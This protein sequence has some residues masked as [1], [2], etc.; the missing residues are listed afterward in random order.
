MKPGG[1]VQP[2]RGHPRGK[3]EHAGERDRVGQIGGAQVTRRGGGAAGSGLLGDGDELRA[4]DQQGHQP[5]QRGRPQLRHRR[6]PDQ[7]RHQRRARQDDHQHGHL[8]IS[9][10]R[11]ADH[12][13]QDHRPPPPRPPRQPHRGLQRQRQEQR[14]R[15]QVQVIP[16][17]PRQ[18]R[19]QPEKRPRRDRAHLRGQPQPR[20]PVHRITQ[21]PR[22]HHRQ[23]VVRRARPEHHRDRH[24]HHARQRHQRM[25][26]QLS[27]RRSIDITGKPRITQ[28]L[29]LP[30]NPPEPPHVTTRITRRRQ[31]ARQIRHPR[32]AHRDPRRHKPSQHPQLNRHRTTNHPEN[33]PPPE[34]ARPATI[35]PG[36]RPPD[37]SPD[38][39][40]HAGRPHLSRPHTGRRYRRTSRRTRPA[41]CGR[42]GTTR[43]HG[44][45]GPVNGLCRAG[46]QRP[47]PVT[48][49]PV[50]PFLA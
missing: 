31:P 46:G 24:H 22:H 30:R 45:A 25:Q 26:P 7:P 23:Q 19:R 42:P 32:P 40:T 16:G 35:R 9:Q 49:R 2:E 15:G 37:R 38:R 17:P 20:H 3:L 36:I 13:P 39:R 43:R 29:H 8:L 12:H 34:P 21:Q 18:H 6:T 5:G 11:P 50:H 4:G 48:V 14:P 27:P 10:Q 1:D 47:L 44:R 41:Q 33:P 28:M